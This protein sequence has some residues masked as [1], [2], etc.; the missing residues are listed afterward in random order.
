MVLSNLDCFYLARE[1]SSLRGEPLQKAYCEP[2]VFRFKF[3][4]ADV[5]VRLPDAVYFT[6]SPPAF[7]KHPGPWAMRLRKL[8]KGRLLDVK[9]VGFDRIVRL[10]FLGASVVFELFAD[11][12]VLVLDSQDTIVLPF[13]R[14]TYAARSLAAK[15]A[16]VSPPMDKMHPLEF[17]A[18]RL[19]SQGA[20]ISALSK[21]VNL[22]PLYLEEACLRAGLKKTVPVATLSGEEKK[23]LT[24][25]L[26]SLLDQRL[27][28]RVYVKEGNAFA[29]A[30]FALLVFKELPFEATSSFSEA[31]QRVFS[32]SF[33]VGV[34]LATA[35]KRKAAVQEQQRLALARFEEKAAEARSKGEWIQA[36]APL[37]EWLKSDATLSEKDVASHA[38]NLR[39]TR[40]KNELE[41]QV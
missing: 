41:F 11:G 7:D 24:N 4:S 39:F 18:E 36:N 3:K 17:D 12:N 29:A 21:A 5:V 19:P 1:L 37:I 33:A 16:Y 27:S 13:R 38:P 6:K 9:Q 32:A 28:P 23:A 31:L 34:P 22:S 8:V 40:N 26:S 2:P 25:A 35:Q 20:L 15:T 14:E 10:D 30:P